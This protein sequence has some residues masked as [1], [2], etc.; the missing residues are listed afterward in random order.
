VA[1]SRACCKNGAVKLGIIGDPV[2]HSLSPRMHGAALV[3]LG[4]EGD[5]ELLP[6]PV[7]RLAARMEE[8]RSGYQGVNVTVP[9]K[10]AVMEHLDELD[11]KAAMIGAVNTVV[12]RGGRLTGYNTDAPG[13]YWALENAGLTPGEA[14]VLGAGG[15]AR[16]IVYEL[17]NRGWLVAVYNRT[18]DKAQELV[19]QLGGWLVVGKKIEK[20]VTETPLLINA[21]SVGLGD[22]DASPLPGGVLPESGAVVDIVYEPRKTK[23]LRDA[24]AAGLQTLGGLEMLL[25]QGVL[26]F[27]LWTGGPAP[28]EVMRRAL[29]EVE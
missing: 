3:A 15:A 20:A 18:A 14:L 27:E 25:G 5:Y 26:A 9:H 21:T 24:E 29:G 17:V 2:E 16:A 13:F 10:R 28:V 22:P 6:T 8:V 1:K 7:A 23:L 4:I 11:N 19:E 12:N